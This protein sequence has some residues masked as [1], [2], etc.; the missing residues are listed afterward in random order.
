[1]KNIYVCSD[2]HVEFEQHVP[3]DDVDAS[4]CAGDITNFGLEKH[5][6]S[7]GA[8]L[9]LNECAKIAP[10]FYIPGNHDLGV[11]QGN[12]FVSRAEN[13]LH[14]KVKFGDYSMTGASMSPCYNA[15]HL[16]LVEIM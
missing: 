1:M 7:E 13:I 6:E 8:T 10:T 5:S 12:N 2:I 14:K 16:A 3:P 9:W 11:R 15:P 4:I